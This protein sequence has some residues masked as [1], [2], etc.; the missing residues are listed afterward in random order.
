MGFF[1]K[2]WRAVKSIV[3]VVVKAIVGLVMRIVHILG[4]ILTLGLV[5]KKLTIQVMI[6]RDERSSPLIAEA[7]IQAAVTSTTTIF[8][9]RFNVAVRMYGKPGVQTIDGPAPTAA[10]DDH[11]DIDAYA[12]DFGEAGEF[13]ATH[14]AG[15]VGIPISL[16]FPVTVFVVR[17]VDGK[18]GC[19]IPITDYVTLSATSSSGGVTGVTDPTTMAHELAHTCLLPHRD[20]I[21]N[22]LYPS[23]GR[24]TETTW[25]QRRVA[26]TSRHVTFW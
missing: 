1:R 16:R 8:K 5:T 4:E 7:A 15:W 17:T 2:L 11:C 25:W 26:R 19:S 23:A 6:L 22:L 12:E 24:G 13:Y 10:L 20:N 18:I 3:R 14:T 21:S 9:D